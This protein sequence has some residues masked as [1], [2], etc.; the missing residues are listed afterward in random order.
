[1]S[2]LNLNENFTFAHKTFAFSLK[3]FAYPEKHFVRYLYL[4]YL[5]YI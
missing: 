5:Y 1:M 4:A 2:N 3:T